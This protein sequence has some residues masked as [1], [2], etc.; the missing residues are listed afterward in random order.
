MTH[1]SLPVYGARLPAG[2]CHVAP[3]WTHKK[4]RRDGYSAEA[5]AVQPTK[6]CVLCVSDH[7]ATCE[8]LAA[9]LGRRGY[10]VVTA[11]SLVT[12][13][14]AAYGQVFSL[15]VLDAEVWGGAGARLCVSISACDPLAPILVFS[16][17]AGAG[18]PRKALEAGATRYILKPDLVGLVE[19]AHDLASEA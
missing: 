19:A 7:G 17:A 5:T 16:S 11:R 15:Y 4:S 14:L 12:A 9:V 8:I 13:L 3:T 6:K 18:A 2:R 1:P 10:E